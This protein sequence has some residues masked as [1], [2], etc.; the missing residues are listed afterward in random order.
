MGELLNHPDPKDRSSNSI[1]VAIIDNYWL[2]LSSKDDKTISYLSESGDF[3]AP[4]II[5]EVE[6]KK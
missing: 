1:F 4:G 2:F 6:G 5:I 3:Y